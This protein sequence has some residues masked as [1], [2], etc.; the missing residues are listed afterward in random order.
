[1]CVFNYLFNALYVKHIEL[2][3]VKLSTTVPFSADV[4]V[5]VVFAS[6]SR[7]GHIMIWDSRMRSKGTPFKNIMVTFYMVV[8]RK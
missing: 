5:S 7:D 1:M 8:Y 2:S 6:G 4:F 3:R